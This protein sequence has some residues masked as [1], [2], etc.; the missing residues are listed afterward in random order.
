M[1]GRLGSFITQCNICEGNGHLQKIN[2]TGQCLPCAGFGLDIAPCH[3]CSDEKILECADTANECFQFK[4]YVDHGTDRKIASKMSFW[5][6]SKPIEHM[7]LR[8]RHCNHLFESL[9]DYK[10]FYQNQEP[11][12]ACGKNMNSRSRRIA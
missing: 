9:S 2:H 11:C 1:E 12:P 8:C 5:N 10:M 3:F 7:Q 6:P 4:Q